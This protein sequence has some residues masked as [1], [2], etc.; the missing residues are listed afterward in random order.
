MIGSRF[1]RRGN[2][3]IHLPLVALCRAQKSTFH[4]AQV[5]DLSD[6]GARLVIQ[7]SAPQGSRLS[8]NI[9]LEPEKSISVEAHVVWSKPS[10]RP[11]ETEVGVCLG[12]GNAVARRAIE[13]WVRGQTIRR[14]AP[15]RAVHI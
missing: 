14:V 12:G 11:G 13:I 5:C 6:S 2:S 9:K 3:R 4:R 15:K 1:D 10:Y 8:L 7:D